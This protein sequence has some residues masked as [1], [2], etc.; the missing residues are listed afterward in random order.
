MKVYN[1]VYDA[2]YGSDWFSEYI[3]NCTREEA[4]DYLLSKIDIDFYYPS[5]CIKKIKNKEFF[6]MQEYEV[7]EQLWRDYLDDEPDNIVETGD[8]EKYEIG[9]G[10][11]GLEYFI[12]DKIKE[13]IKEEQVLFSKLSPIIDFP[14]DRRC[15]YLDDGIIIRED[16]NI[17]NILENLDDYMYDIKEWLDAFYELKKSTLHMEISVSDVIKC[18]RRIEDNCNFN[19]RI[20]ETHIPENMRSK[21]TDF[22]YNLFEENGAIYWVTQGIFTVSDLRDF[23]KAIK[24]CDIKGVDR[25]YVTCSDL[26]Y[27]YDFKEDK[28]NKVLA[29]VTEEDIFA[30]NYVNAMRDLG[31]EVDG[32]STPTP[33]KIDKK[34]MK[35]EEEC[36]EEDEL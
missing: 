24:E 4:K 27:S 18:E 29:V 28:E 16:N 17:S 19:S 9:I 20:F 32:V 6:Y 3:Q 2:Q 35:C 13:Y 30:H 23:Q 10:F 14:A 11:Y 5:R 34:H 26:S 1:I 33:L 31:F 25:F 7:P 22:I 15:E 12:K 8:L 36:E 21:Q